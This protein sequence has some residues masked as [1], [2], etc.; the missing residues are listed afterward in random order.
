MTTRSD[1]TIPSLPRA[2]TL[3]IVLALAALPSLMGAQ[4]PWSLRVQSDNDAFDFWQQPE[5]R[6]DAE[7]SNG[8]RISFSAGSLISGMEM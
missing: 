1:L 6:P 5:Q 3:P 8:V 7:Y 2:R 4:S